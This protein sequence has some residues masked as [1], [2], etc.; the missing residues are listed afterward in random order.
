M[1]TI[2]PTCQRYWLVLLLFLHTVN[3]YMDRVCIST[4]K[5]S[6]Q[7]DITGLDNGRDA[8]AIRVDVETPIR[9]TLSL[10]DTP[11]LDLI[12]QL[13]IEPSQTGGHAK[14]EAEFAFS[15]R[16]D[17][18]IEN[19]DIKVQGEL[20]DV[21]IHNLLWGQDATQGGLHLDL[22]NDGMRVQGTT[23]FAD[24]P[25]RI[26]WEEALSIVADKLRAADADKIGML[27]SPSATV[28]EAHLLTRL[29][30]HL[31]TDNLD[32][33]PGRRLRDLPP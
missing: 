32:C 27:A 29:A 33:R 13:G 26:D 11:E 10:L 22:N 5:D 28:E 9:D 17:L 18:Q 20:E 8:I 31:G 14:V 24:L 6:M 4:A 12:S 1:K 25:L 16:G 23:R 19:V 21:V 2:A 7:E 15:L 30:A 3:T